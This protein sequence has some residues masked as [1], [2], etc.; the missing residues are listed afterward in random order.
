MH[1]HL[2]ATG[3]TLTAQPH[4]PTAAE[5]D[6][7]TASDYATPCHTV[8]AEC[9]SELVRCTRARRLLRLFADPLE[10]LAPEGLCMAP[11]AL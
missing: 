2:T 7:Q 11:E 4:G 5:G 9:L 10:R 6:G 8:T 1:A 3:D